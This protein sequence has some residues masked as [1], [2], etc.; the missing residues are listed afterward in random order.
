[1]TESQENKLCCY[2]EMGHEEICRG[3]D[4]LEVEK[5]HKQIADLQAKLSEYEGMDEAFKTLQKRTANLDKALFD[6]NK[7]ICQEHGR[8]I[9][10]DCF[11]G[12]QARNAEL[13]KEVAIFKQS[14]VS[15]TDLSGSGWKKLRK[16]QFELKSAEDALAAV[17]EELEKN[18]ALTE[19]IK[20]ANQDQADEI[21]RLTKEI[22][23]AAVDDRTLHSLGETILKRT[24]QR[25]EALA[26]AEAY[27]EV[28]IQDRLFVGNSLDRKEYER[29]ADKEAQRILF[30]K[31]NAWKLSEEIDGQMKRILA[32]KKESI[33]N[34]KQDHGGCTCEC[35]KVMK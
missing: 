20:K 14:W 34:H 24:R 18:L 3:T 23:R 15:I 4:C 6:S 35:H 1:M 30:K 11:N 16:L 8:G 32:E 19:E 5:L 33:C 22:Q 29:Y 31:T 2:C 26:K 13:E 12:L 9:C 17:K 7:T 27:R 28:A 25:D 10:S 21:K